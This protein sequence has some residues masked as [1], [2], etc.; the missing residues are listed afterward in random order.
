MY[1][2]IVRRVSTSIRCRS[3]PS[4]SLK[5]NRED[6]LR[7]RKERCLSRTETFVNAAVFAAHIIH[8]QL[9]AL[10]R[11][12]TKVKLR[13]GESIPLAERCPM[14]MAEHRLSAI[15]FAALDNPERCRSMSPDRLHSLRCLSSR[16]VRPTVRLGKVRESTFFSFLS[17]RFHLLITSRNRV[18]YTSRK[19]VSV[20]RPE[21]SLLRFSLSLRRSA[22]T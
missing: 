8:M 4:Y 22:Y 13:K 9:R 20:K 14:P 19:F 11:A 3:R 21:N 10:Q 18:R 7:A 6:S 1:A 5:R 15:R 17:N 12:K 2:Y 16:I